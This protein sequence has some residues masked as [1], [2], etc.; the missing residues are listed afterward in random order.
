[1]SQARDP[2]CFAWTTT[3]VT[4][5]STRSQHD[6]EYADEMSFLLSAIRRPRLPTPRN[7]QGK[8]TVK[9][10]DKLKNPILAASY[11]CIHV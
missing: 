8:L 6:L 3:P 11:P 1:M 4:A 5:W 9:V 10:N 2:Y 7:R